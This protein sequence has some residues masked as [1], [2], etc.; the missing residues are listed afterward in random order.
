[1][2]ASILKYIWFL[3]VLASGL[4]AVVLGLS[5]YGVKIDFDSWARVSSEILN[6]IPVLLS[7]PLV[8]SYGFYGGLFICL[9]FLAL[10]VMASMAGRNSEG[11]SES[12]PDNSLE[13]STEVPARE[14]IPDADVLIQES[15]SDTDVSAQAA[16]SS[17]DENFPDPADSSDPVLETIPFDQFSDTLSTDTDSHSN[18]D[19]NTSDPIE[20]EFDEIEDETDEESKELLQNI[21]VKGGQ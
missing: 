13:T 21:S 10:F 8:V 6:G 12:E 17:S 20:N 16:F 5:Q 3:L 2:G 11:E 7:S 14:P 19:E 9:V 18:Q 4:V 1:M 15:I